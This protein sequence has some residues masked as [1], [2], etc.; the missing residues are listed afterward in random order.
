[1]EI[2]VR[3]TRV[4]TLFVIVTGLLVLASCE[5]YSWAK[6]EV[7]QDISISFLNNIYPACNSC[8][9]SWNASRTYSNLSANVDTVDPASSRVLSIHSSITS[10]GSKMVQVDTVLLSLPDMVKLWASQGAENN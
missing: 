6:P 7:P 8:H 3:R 9:A 2:K 4:L 5:K 1:M 10:F